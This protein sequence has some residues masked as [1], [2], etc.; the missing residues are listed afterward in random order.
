MLEAAKILAYVALYVYCS[1]KGIMQA[2][3]NAK[4]TTDVF[5]SSL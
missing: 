1:L 3:A 2:M 4:K 5:I